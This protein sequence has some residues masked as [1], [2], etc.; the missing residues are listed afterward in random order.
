M[1]R[2][3]CFKDVL[4]RRDS[5]IIELDEKLEELSRRKEESRKK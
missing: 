3:T 1:N 5:I 2:E 4:E